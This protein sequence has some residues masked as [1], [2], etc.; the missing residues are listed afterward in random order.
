MLCQRALA[1]ISSVID[2]CALTQ[3]GDKKGDKNDGTRINW[4]QLCE[5]IF[6]LIVENQVFIEI[7]VK[8]YETV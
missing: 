6:Q 2:V 7:S 8:H 3:M 5:Q 1:L 4:L